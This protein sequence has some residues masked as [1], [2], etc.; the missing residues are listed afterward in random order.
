M[1]T[2]FTAFETV[3]LQLTIEPQGALDGYQEIMVSIVQGAQRVDKPYP[4]D[5]PEVDGDIINLRL[6]QDETGKFTYYE[7]N[8]CGE[9]DPRNPRIQVNVLYQDEERSTTNI[10]NLDLWEQ[11]YKKKMGA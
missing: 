9:P 8:P 6:E 10:A 11:L 4:K 2:G 1:S 7:P 3:N 5:A